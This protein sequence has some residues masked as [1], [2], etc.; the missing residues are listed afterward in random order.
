MNKYYSIILFLSLLIIINIYPQW[1]NNSQINTPVCTAVENQNE[2]VSA[3]DGQGGTFFAWRDYRNEPTM[4]GGDIYVQKISSDGELLWG[5]DGIPVSTAINGQFRPEI[6]NDGAGNVIIVWADNKGG[7][8]NYDLYAQKLDENSNKL[9]GSNG[10]HVTTD[11]YTD[12]FH[13][14]TSDGNGG[15][16]ITWQRL[17][18]V[19]GTTDIYAQKISADGTIQWTANGL[20]VCQASGSQYYPQLASDGIGGAVIVWSDARNGS[21]NLDIFAQHVNRKG[22]INWTVDGNPVC[23][24]PAVQDLPVICKSN[25]NNGVIIAYEDYRVL[26]GAI[27]VQRL[28]EY[29]EYDWTEN[30]ILISPNG[31]SCSNPAIIQDI[32]GGYIVC[33]IDDV[34]MTETNIMAQKFDEN[35][36]KLWGTDAV[37]VCSATNDQQ[38]IYAISNDAGGITITWQDYRSDSEA[39]IYAQWIDPDGNAM[40]GIDGIG[41]S[42]AQG[43]EEYPVCTADGIGG[44]VISWVDGRNGTDDIYTQNV[45]IQGQLGTQIFW[46]TKNNINKPVNDLQITADTILVTIGGKSS[47]DLELTDGTLIID[48]LFHQLTND[49]EITVEHGGIIDTIAYHAGMQGSDFIHTYLNDNSSIYLSEGDPPFSGIYIPFSKLEKFGGTDPAGEWIINIYDSQTG[50][51]GTLQSWGV[52]LS[53]TSITDVKQITENIPDDFIL[54][55]NYP[56]PFNPSTKIKFTISDLQFTILKVYNVLGKEVAT[57]VNEKLPAGNYEVDFNAS[58]LPSGIYF[59][60]LNAGSYSSTKKMIILK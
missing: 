50:N 57:L 43:S 7:F 11:F 60:R 38:N 49:L 40:W 36:N 58:N 27:Y 4:F 53:F 21:S 46:W 3:T 42:N 15:V 23:T 19:P 33:W 34:Q 26:D 31:S 52:A 47:T 24:D 32:A 14:I 51:T 28:N 54:Y 2:V 25:V 48:T 55:Q 56:N 39:D 5:N 8:Y 12:S 45:D 6:I 20:P 37:T 17:A 59:Y 41:V 9:W 1:S 16:I 35:A 13:Q 18:N 10:V 22:T 30:G 44:A 29:G